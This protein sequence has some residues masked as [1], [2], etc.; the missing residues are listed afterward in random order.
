MRNSIYFLQFLTV[1]IVSLGLLVWASFHLLSLKTITEDA[2]ITENLQPQKEP[3]GATTCH[4]A[5]S[6]A[7]LWQQGN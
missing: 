6:F 4:S 5:D 3:S 7:R 2:L 1:A